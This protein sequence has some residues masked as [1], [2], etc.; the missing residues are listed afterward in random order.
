MKVSITDSGRSP[1]SGLHGLRLTIHPGAE[2]VVEI[3]S[4]DQIADGKAGQS[5]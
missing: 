2:C 3:V 5:G 1:F 4:P